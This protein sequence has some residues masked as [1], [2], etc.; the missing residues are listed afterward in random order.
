MY[1]ALVEE[2]F[3]FPWL[4]LGK[5]NHPFICYQLALVTNLSFYN[6]KCYNKQDR[7]YLEEDLELLQHPRWSA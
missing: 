7:K 3:R 6:E 2:N 1:A 5:F 4:M